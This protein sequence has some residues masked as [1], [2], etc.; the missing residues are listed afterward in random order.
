M[1]IPLSHDLSLHA[2][3]GISML[4]DF[5][6]FE[7]KYSPSATKYAAPF[8]AF[9]Y[10]VFYAT[11]VEHC[12]KENGVCKPNMFSSGAILMALMYSSL[13]FFD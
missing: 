5:V 6:L 10:G 9:V 11:W 12:G 3:P 13:P 4:L 7:S 8:V 2:V 1:R